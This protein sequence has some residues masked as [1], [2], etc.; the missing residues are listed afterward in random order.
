MKN[1]SILLLCVLLC[2]V[3]AGCSKKESAS[4]VESTAEINAAA[5][6]FALGDIAGRNI[7]LSAFKGK[8]V[9]LEFWATWCPPCK[10]SVPAMSALHDKY[11]QKGF[12][13]IGVS[14]DTGSDA[15]EMV[16]QFAS[17]HN[18]TYPVLLANETTPKLY[19]VTSVPT[20][21]LIGKDGKIVDIFRGYSEEFDKLVAA[22]IEKLL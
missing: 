18:I 9:L 14:I 20:S 22:K 13:V 5:P 19:N 16:R 2:L 21:F 8:V 7:S 10:A 1:R 4:L 3:A 12:S 17:S 6:E 15:L 11:A